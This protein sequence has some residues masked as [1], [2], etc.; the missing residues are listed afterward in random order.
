MDKHI[1]ILNKLGREVV[2]LENSFEG[3]VVKSVPGIKETWFARFSG[4]VE[5]KIDSSSQVVM[6]A[7]NEAKE[8]NE[9]MY[10]NY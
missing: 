1:N 10:L 6:E 5:Y 4:G 2:F 9:V 8:I 3:I 7:I